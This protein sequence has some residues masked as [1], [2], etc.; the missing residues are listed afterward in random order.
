[1]KTVKISTEKPYQ[2]IDGWGTSLCWWANAA[3]GWTMIGDSGKEKRE[4]LMELFFSREGLNFNICRYNIGG[5]DNPDEKRHMF[6]FRGI[7]CFRAASDSNF[8]RNADWRQTWVLKRA[9]EIRKDDIINEVFVNSPPWWMTNSLCSSGNTEAG[10][11]NLDG[12]RYEEFIDFCAEVLEFL[13][14]DLKIKTDYFVPMNEAA[15]DYWAKGQRQEGNKVNQGQS[16]SKLLTAAYEKFKQR[17]LKIE[18]TGTDE[19]N[20]AIAL[21]SYHMLNDEVKKKVLKKINYHRYSDDDAALEQLHQIAYQNDYANPE[22]KLWMDEV[23]YG[24][25][26]DDIELAKNLIIAINKDLNIAHANA[27]VIWQAMDT[28]SENIMNH[29]HWGLV[30]GMYQDKSNN[31]LEG[32]LDV[33]SMGYESGDYLVTTQYYVMGHYSK[34]IKKGYSILKNDG[35]EFFCVSA[36]SPDKNT[37]V[38][39]LYNDAYQRKTVIVDLDGFTPIKA[40]KIDSNNDKKWYRTVMTEDLKNILLEPKSI[41]TLIFE[42]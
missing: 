12:S 29:C 25:G 28:M 20:P 3:G 27:W 1:M 19:T 6:H 31:E 10:D 15:S 40:T 17:N 7:P 14:N 21:K 13:T 18:I 26:K 23:C 8:D 36:I 16:Q 22:Y 30:E 5:G 38:V 4:E 41:S 42:K 24:D 37:V 35:E 33:E 32:I 9:N 34:Y 2:I 11:E 39:V